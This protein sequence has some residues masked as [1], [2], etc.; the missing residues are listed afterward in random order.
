MARVLL[1]C[2]G[3]LSDFIGHLI[4]ELKARGL[5][6]PE[7]FTEYEIFN[8]LDDKTSVIAKQLLNDGQ[9]WNMMPKHEEAV[10]AVEALKAAGHDIAVV[11]T[12]W[13]SCIGWE[14]C[15]RAWLMRHFQLRPKRMIPVFEKHWVHGDVFVDDKPAHLRDWMRAW[16]KGR[17][18]LMDRPWS[19]GEEIECPR[20]SWDPAGVEALLS[21]ARA[22]S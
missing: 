4:A 22:S 15:R 19:Q 13:T 16:P 18:F 14:F 12:P 21:A 5:P 9:F 20:I 2:D 6:V 17:A 8:Q 11:T 10:H 3:V 7:T 1:D